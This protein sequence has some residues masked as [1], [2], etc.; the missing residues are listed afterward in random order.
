MEKISALQKHRFT[1]GELL[2]SQSLPAYW[3]VILCHCRIWLFFLF[4]SV[5]YLFIRIINKHTWLI[6]SIL[7]K[8]ITNWCLGAMYHAKCKWDSWMEDILPGSRP[9]LYVGF[10]SKQSFYKLFNAWTATEANRDIL[11]INCAPLIAR[12]HQL[13]IHMDIKPSVLNLLRLISF[14]GIQLREGEART[15]FSPAFLCYAWQ[16]SS[17]GFLCKQGKL[18]FLSSRP[19]AS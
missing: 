11:F 19:C 10:L 18:P 6:W 8:W 5:M 14:N 7:V 1:L 16:I 4:L 15:R 2:K 13:P 9:C 17:L 12:S 3:A